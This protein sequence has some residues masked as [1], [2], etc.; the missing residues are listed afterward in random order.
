M[1]L[2]DMKIVQDEWEAW[3]KVMAS[4]NETGAITTEDGE[5]GIADHSTPGRL[6]LQRI[7]RWGEELARLRIHQYAEHLSGTDSHAKRL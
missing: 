1:I 4:L 5:A 6:L 3:Q 2:D 7:R